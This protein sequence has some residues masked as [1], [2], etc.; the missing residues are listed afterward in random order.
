MT[1][2]ERNI[3]FSKL[4]AEITKN[5]TL[6]EC[7]L[8]DSF[9]DCSNDI[10]NAHSLQR[11][12][13]LARIEY[14]V[15]GNNGVYALTEKQL[16][17]Q[18]G[19]LELKP[20]GKKVA[21]TFFGFCG[22]HDLKLFQPIEQNPDLI[23][24]ES[25]EHCF[26]LSFRAFAISCH[27]KKEDINLLSKQD[28]PLRNKIREYFNNSD[29]ESQL[30]ISKIGLQDLDRYKGILIQALKNKEYD[31]LDY[32]TYELDYTVPVAMSMMTTP[33]F[34]FSGKPININSD[35]NYQY[36]D[37]LTTVIPLESRSLIILAAF[38]DDP[39]GSEFLTELENMSD[40]EFQKAL[41]WHI[42]TNSENCFFSPKWFDKMDKRQKQ[43]IIELNDFSGA[44]TTPYLKYD[45]NRFNINI[46]DKKHSI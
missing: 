9:E 27:R 11:M 19:L 18:T 31:S 1:F 24:L 36:S 8:S 42:I 30:E 32:L 6:K 12:G 23:D 37:I 10:I 16:N 4:K 40:L 2:E 44:V 17:P 25:D 15:N 26:L 39:F 41:T 22:N 33:P 45:K 38:P 14:N 5:A 3:E 21:S 46:L 28:E 20:I 7:L 29:I 13:A 35:P 43:F 34:L